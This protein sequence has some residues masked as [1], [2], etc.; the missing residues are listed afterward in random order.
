MTEDL[1]RRWVRG[2]LQPA[3]RRDV[4][5]WIVRCTAPDLGP[6]MQAIALEHRDEQRDAALSARGGVWPR[7]L[8]RWNALL[9]AGRAYA[10]LGDDAGVVLASVGTA[11][12]PRSPL[13]IVVDGAGARVTFALSPAPS[14]AIEVALY[15]T[16]D[17]GVVSRLIAPTALTG[18]LSAP[19]PATSGPRATVWAISASAIPRDNDV[20]IEL[21]R[22]TDAPGAQVWAVRLLPQ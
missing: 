21:D 8:V 13:T 5:R 19:L 2:E 7:L 1:L 18:S 17:D 12:D 6:L 9:D 20:A 3:E 4:S 11:A 15:L 22:A 10:T 16:D 14:P